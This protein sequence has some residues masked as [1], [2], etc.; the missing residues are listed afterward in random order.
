[1]S[2]AEPAVDAGAM[3]PG[4]LRTGSGRVRRLGL[5][6]VLGLGG[7]LL[8]SASSAVGRFFIDPPRTDVEAILRSPSP[9]HPLGTDFAGR[10][11]LLLLMRGGWD[12]LEL[13]VVA[14]FPMTAIAVGVG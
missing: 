9:D 4:T 5:G 11:N 10:D 1:M 6:G 8:L 14:G 13:A 7:L 2:V 3:S 12:M